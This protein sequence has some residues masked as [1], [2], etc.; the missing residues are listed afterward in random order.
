M[1]LFSR[2][3][4]LAL[5]LAGCAVCDAADDKSASEKKS[6]EPVAGNGAP[7]ADG[8]VL[9][10]ESTETFVVECQQCTLSDLTQRPF[11][12]DVTL[13]QAE[14]QGP[15]VAQPVVDILKEGTSAE[16]RVTR[17]NDELL[18]VEATVSL[19]DIGEV[20]TRDIVKDAN[21]PSEKA[22]VQ[23][24]EHRSFST[25]FVSYVKL[26]HIFTTVFP[27]TESDAPT[28]EFQFVVTKDGCKDPEWTRTLQ[29][30][31]AHADAS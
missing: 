2:T 1:K 6:P 22:T 24:P 12:T 31:T 27:R 25:S 14:P 19:S 8:K 17:I 4:V 3:A 26:G 9:F 10:D 11:V 28:S 18:K 13:E 20:R 16:I 30:P 7:N 21:R 23:C 29:H 15:V 5:M